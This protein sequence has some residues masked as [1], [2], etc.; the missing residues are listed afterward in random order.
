MSEY[1]TELRWWCE[2][3]TGLSGKPVSQIIEKAAPILFQFYYPF[4]SE[5][6]N[7]K[8]LF[9]EKIIR[10]FYTREIG[11]ETMGLFQLKLEDKMLEIMPYYNKLYSAANME[12]NFLNTDESSEHENE[13]TK[14]SG[15]YSANGEVSSKGNSKYSD[16]PQGSISGL[17]NGDYMT[18][19]EINV[20]ASNSSNN[21]EN[22]GEGTRELT[23][24]Y[25]GRKG[26]S[27]GNLLAE[28]YKAQMNIDQQLYKELNTLFMNIW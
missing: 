12:F 17:E 14:T 25:T 7:E 11:F 4:W 13:S 26:V 10:H 19:A 6:P 20:N 21:G 5:N 3:T 27:A 2:Q 15:E 24:T 8:R 23:R 22:K 9:Q 1:T 28:Y 18:N 16:T